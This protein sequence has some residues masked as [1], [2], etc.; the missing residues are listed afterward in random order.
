MPRTRAIGEI[1]RRNGPVKSARAIDQS[2]WAVRSTDGYLAWKRT[3]AAGT[4]RG[5]ENTSARKI[6]D[7]VRNTGPVGGRARVYQ[8]D[9]RPCRDRGRDRSRYR[10]AG[11]RNHLGEPIGTGFPAPSCHFAVGHLVRV[12]ALEIIAVHVGTEVLRIALGPVERADLHRGGQLNCRG[13]ARSR[14]QKP[15]GNPVGGDQVRADF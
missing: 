14:Y 4:C 2:D 11:C 8:G 7:L 13:S 9:R 5:E 3:S 1:L 6:I 12:R 15:Q 10:V